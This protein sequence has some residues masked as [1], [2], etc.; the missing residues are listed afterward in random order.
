MTTKLKI[1]DIVYMAIVLVLMVLSVLVGVN[2]LFIS[3][4][5][6]FSN[7]LK[8]INRI[9]NI[10]MSVGSFF[11]N[12]KKLPESLNELRGD[13][14]YYIDQELSIDP[15]SGNPIV[16]KPMPSGKNYKICLD[17]EVGS[18]RIIEYKNSIFKDNN[19]LS[20]LIE[21]FE[22]YRNSDGPK[23]QFGVG[24]QCIDFVVTKSDNSKPAPYRY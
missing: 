10:N 17:F 8:R 11:L 12:K 21:T 14:L 22:K 23:F 13:V 18:N 2:F 1:K 4:L 3:D 7:D 24:Y 20:T 9:N 19:D 15:V 16:Y 5:R 6:K